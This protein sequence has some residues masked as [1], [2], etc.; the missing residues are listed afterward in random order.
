M[1]NQAC[2]GWSGKWRI[3]GEYRLRSEGRS[4]LRT[5]AQ[6][7]GPRLPRTPCP[8]HLFWRSEWGLS[9]GHCRWKSVPKTAPY[10]RMGPGSRHGLGAS[11]G[12]GR[13]RIPAMASSQGD[14]RSSPMAY[15]HTQRC[16]AA[17]KTPATSTASGRRA[18]PVS[19]STCSAMT[20]NNS[21]PSPSGHPLLSKSPTLK[22][23]LSD[24][25]SPTLN[26]IH[27]IFAKTVD[28][29]RALG[30]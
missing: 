4:T 9:R 13:S 19:S 22:I 27:Q 26:D 21:V 10:L 5:D 6:T 17:A 16:A 11:L 15:I 29:S 7:L 14:V 30:S 8:A 24:L 1:A 23:R 18:L 20:E 28:V 2:T 25:F 12:H 3:S